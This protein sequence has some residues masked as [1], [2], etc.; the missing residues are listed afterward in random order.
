MK[1]FI[2]LSF[3]V[4]LSCSAHAQIVQAPGTTTT[5][6]EE[7]I[8]ETPGGRVTETT[9]TQPGEV[10]VFNPQQQLM[11][12]PRAVEVTPGRVVEKETTVTEVDGRVYIDERHVVVVDGREL[13]YTTIPVLFVKETAEL[14]DKESRDALTKTAAAIL[15]VVEA[16]PTATFQIEG[17]ASV[18]GTD[19]FNMKLSADRAK[20]VHA[21]LTQRYQVPAT[22]LTARA[23]GKRYPL[24]PEGT[25]AE[26]MLDRRVLV[27]RTQ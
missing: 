12:A 2:A 14:L 6:V 26:R 4:A 17:H 5:V 16:N 20:R 15:E 25:E 11:I 21:E 27:V 19:E 22:V 13:P 18:E 10:V 1:K 3:I 8:T 9:V 24:H 23:Y 7:V